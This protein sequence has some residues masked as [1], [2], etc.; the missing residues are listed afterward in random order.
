MNTSNAVPLTRRFSPVPKS[1]GESD[2]QKIHALQGYG[3]FLT[4]EDIEKGY[5]SVVLAEAGAGKTFEMQARATYV[6]QEGRAA[7]FIRIEDIESDFGQS[8]EIGDAESF[9][10]WLGSERDAW[11]YLDSVDEARLE[12]PAGFERAVR[13][14]SRAIR[15]AQHRAHVCIS[16]RPYAWRPQ[17]DR[18]LIGQYLPLPKALAEAIAGDVQTHDAS[19][20][21]VTPMVFALQAA[22][23]K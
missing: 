18:L 20:P 6:E 21:Q 9:E 13:R 7:F 2:E 23:R 15:K 5:R 1:A 3:T 12:S 14:F 4:W 17:S 19:E 11:F 8:F 22:R 10:Q 16:S